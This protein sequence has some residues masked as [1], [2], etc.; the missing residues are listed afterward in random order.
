[1]LLVPEVC[2]TFKLVGAH[3]E[4]SPVYVPAGID[5]VTRAISKVLDLW[6]RE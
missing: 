2:E 6:L 1:M 4:H 3:A 5:P